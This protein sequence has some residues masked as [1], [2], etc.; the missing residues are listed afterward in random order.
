MFGGS[1]RRKQAEEAA[2]LEAQKAAEEQQRIDN[3]R[4]LHVHELQMTVSSVLQE[5]AQLEAQKVELEEEIF[6]VK[7]AYN[8][9]LSQAQDNCKSLQGQLNEALELQL[10][11]QGQVDTLNMKARD[12]QR[13][14]ENERNSA[15]DVQGQLTSG[16]EEAQEELREALE[17]NERVAGELENAKRGARAM[18]DSFNSNEAKLH[19]TILGMKRE[20]D[21]LTKMQRVAVKISAEEKEASDAVIKGLEHKLTEANGHGA[22]LV[23]D[24]E[25]LKRGLEASLNKGKEMLAAMEMSKDSLI[26]EKESH[27]EAIK[28]AQSKHA[29]ALDAAKADLESQ[30]AALASE[31]NDS[32]TLAVSM[33]GEME[34]GRAKATDAEFLF[35]AKIGDLESKLAL[36]QS[37]KQEA[38][39]VL[40]SILESAKSESD[41][42][43]NKLKAELVSIGDQHNVLLEKMQGEARRMDAQQQE[44]TSIKAEYE[45]HLL[46]SGNL[47]TQQKLKAEEL[48]AAHARVQEL[49][50][51]LVR[52]EAEARTATHRLE[53]A[54]NV[55]AQ[56]GGGDP[57]VEEGTEE[58]LEKG[59]EE[60][61]GDAAANSGPTLADQK[62]VDENVALKLAQE[63]LEAA[64]V[65]LKNE[66][67]SMS[68]NFAVE[69]ESFLERIKA[70]IMEKGNLE[71]ELRRANRR[72]SELDVQ[73]KKTIELSKRK[74]SEMAAS[75]KMIVRLSEELKKKNDES[76]PM[77]PVPP[78]P[79]YE[80]ATAGSSGGGQSVMAAGALAEGTIGD[81]KVVRVIF[82]DGPMGIGLSPLSSGSNITVIRNL[83]TAAA[84]GGKVTG[85]EKHNM[86]PGNEQNQVIP[87]MVL[88]MVNKTAIIGTPYPQL[89]EMLMKTGRPVQLTFSVLTF[90]KCEGEEDT[91]PFLS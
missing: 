57:Q 8:D 59:A 91:N 32:R 77:A 74:D 36:A 50:K 71:V 47:K 45:T 58:N 78:P 19:A 25:D 61:S 1:A 28:A 41:E 82:E 79:Q 88:K 17:R 89:I 31:L 80:E 63:E 24:N 60:S 85:V 22:A 65:E 46:E 75:N 14:R 15:L 64:I 33:K 54:T 11:L 34:S 21:E 66:R 20:I 51:A 39:N 5:N 18:E 68:S 44:H 87:G 76:A 84:K 16:L 56:E 86:E 83:N 73:M 3:E 69:K 53:E 37:E 10:Q 35:K 62:V 9:R 29:T 90:T 13:E 4:N 7:K 49:E 23:R 40:H 12:V 2:A 72:A 55:V 70:E 52:A 67:H 42:E 38:E 26:A 48:L 6:H 43:K 30:L 27:V 81:G